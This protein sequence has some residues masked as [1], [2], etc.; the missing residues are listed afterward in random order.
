MMLPSIAVVTRSW[1]ARSFALGAGLVLGLV[2]GVSR[3]THSHHHC[4]RGR[5]AAVVAAGRPTAE[6]AASTATMRP[7]TWDNG[8]MARLERAK[9]DLANWAP[10]FRRAHI[11]NRMWDRP[12]AVNGRSVWLELPPQYLARISWSSAEWGPS[13]YDWEEAP[14]PVVGSFA[15]HRR[16]A[17]VD[18]TV[19]ADD[20]DLR[21]Q[22]FASLMQPL[23]DDCLMD[24]P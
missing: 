2:A 10:E 23:L 4:C 11:R 7:R 5:T 20:S 19:V 13:V 18:L 16:V 1:T 21:G 6:V 24:V 8:C 14:T 15:L 17:H 22:H 9:R 3:T 12:D